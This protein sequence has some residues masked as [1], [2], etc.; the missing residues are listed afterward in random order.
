MQARFRDARRLHFVEQLDRRL[1]VV[2][3]GARRLHDEMRDAGDLHGRR[4]CVAGRIDDEQVDRFAGDGGVHVAIG[5]HRERRKHLMLLAQALPARGRPLHGIEIGEGRRQA[6]TGTDCGEGA[7]EGGF[8][9][10]AFAAYERNY[11]CHL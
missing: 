8:S 11:D 5:L 1:Q 7:G 9:N 6:P 3:A 2:E 4:R 10:S